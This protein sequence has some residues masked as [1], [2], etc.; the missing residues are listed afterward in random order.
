VRAALTG[1][2]VFST[3]H[4]NDAP[5][6]VSRLMDIGVEPF[7]VGSSLLL[8]VAQRLVRKLC[9]KCKE[10]YVPVS[11]DLPDKLKIGLKII[12]KL[13]RA[14]GC[15]ACGHTGYLGRM[16]IFE[17]MYVNE[18]IEQLVLKR[19]SA[20]EISA[21]AKRSGMMTLEENGIKKV[22]AGETS[23]EELVRVILS[24]D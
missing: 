14:K 19:A 15:T 21:A 23:V 9:P 12:G 24:S 6:A 17:M 22:L 7:F 8:V 10:I 11:A 13:Y 1:H 5:S 18:E 20:S 3:L 4:T 16:A 2:L